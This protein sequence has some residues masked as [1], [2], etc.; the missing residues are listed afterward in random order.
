MTMKAKPADWSIEDYL[1]RQRGLFIAGVDE[2]GRGAWA[3][4]M[5]AAAAVY[6][7]SVVLSCI[8][9]DSK[10]LTADERQRVVKLLTKDYVDKG[11][12]H[13]AYAQ[14]EPA[15]IEKSN[16]N[17]LNMQLFKDALGK[18]PQF[19]QVIIDGSIAD[20]TFPGICAPKADATSITVATAAIFAKVYRDHQMHE[21]HKE[22]PQYGFDIHLGYGTKTHVAAI[23]R[24]GPIRGTHRHNFLQNLR[25]QTA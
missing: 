21:L 8:L 9:R 17:Q 7:P 12:L 18:L 20:D 5:V 14:A 2:V 23:L 22:Y 1:G 16:L 25:N 24:H 4:N 6:A 15:L 3:G 19:D 11:S 10:V 13:V